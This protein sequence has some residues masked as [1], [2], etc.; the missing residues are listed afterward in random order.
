MTLEFIRGHSMLAKAMLDI[1][2]HCDNLSTIKKRH[3]IICIMVNS[4][5]YII[6]I[7][8]L[9]TLIS[10]ENIFIDCKIKKKILQIHYHSFIERTVYNSLRGMS[11]KSLKIK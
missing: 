1:C 11:L 2:V 5:I 7:I 4:D 9:N 6:D 8:S 10:N 3:K